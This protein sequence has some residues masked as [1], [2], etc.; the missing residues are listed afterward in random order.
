[1]LRIIVLPIPGTSKITAR[2]SQVFHGRTLVGDLLFQR[3]AAKHSAVRHV[4]N[5]ALVASLARITV[6]GLL[7][8]FGWSLASHLEAQVSVL[9]PKPAFESFPQQDFLSITGKGAAV[10]YLG[11]GLD[12]AHHV[13]LRLENLVRFFRRWDPEVAI[14]LVAYTVDRDHWKSIG[15]PG[16]YGLPLR[17]SPSAVFVPAYGDQEAVRMWRSAL[18][19]DTLPLVA[20]TP[21]TGTAEEVAS[22]ALA[23]VMMQLETARGFVVAS[24]LKGRDGW[25]QEVVSHLA[26]LI[27]FQQTEPHRMKDLHDVFVRLRDRMGGPKRYDAQHFSQALQ[28]G[29]EEE[30]KAWLWYQGVFYSGAEV[31]LAKDGKRSIQR[32]LKMRQPPGRSLNSA[33]LMKRYPKLRGWH[34]QWFKPNT[35]M[36]GLS[37]ASLTGSANAIQ[38][39]GAEVKS[40]ATTV[41]LGATGSM[42]LEP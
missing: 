32:L 19:V 13:L 16:L 26:A 8:V 42:A 5:T 40:G 20:G 41:V 9:E 7:A 38:A 31:I 15:I 36:P 10:G 29:Q 17:T 18:G 21:V 2:E 11:G 37:T 12:R 14:L 3:A 4:S 27:A 23:D 28:R 39:F 24:G 22:L 30:V 25:I 33:A 6:T 35:G 1:M 34:A